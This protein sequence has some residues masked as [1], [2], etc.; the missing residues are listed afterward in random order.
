MNTIVTDWFIVSVMD[1]EEHVGDVIWG[2]VVED[3]SCRFFKGDKQ[4]I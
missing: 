2:I 3:N 4:Q 1:K